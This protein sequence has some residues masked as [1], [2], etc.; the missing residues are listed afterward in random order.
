[1]ICLVHEVWGAPIRIFLGLYLLWVYLGTASFVGIATGAVLIP[2]V[3]VIENAANSFKVST[4]LFR[5]VCFDAIAYVLH[6][7]TS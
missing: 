5:V 7:W 4:H 3:V 2:L 6:S 1:M